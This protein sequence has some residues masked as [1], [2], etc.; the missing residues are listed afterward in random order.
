VI[1]VGHDHSGAPAVTPSGAGL[2]GDVL[3]LEIAFVQVQFIRPHI[4]GEIHIGQAIVV[5]V[6]DSDPSTVVKVPVV[7]N[8]EFLAVR[9]VVRKWDAVGDSLKKWGIFRVLL[10]SCEQEDAG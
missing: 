7:E 6:A 5:N 2:F 10:A 4:G 1:E 3:K 9:D 8:V